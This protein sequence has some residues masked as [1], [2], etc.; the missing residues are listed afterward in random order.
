MKIRMGDLVITG[1]INEIRPLF[2]QLSIRDMETLERID[3]RLH[4][5]LRDL[6]D[7]ELK[8]Q[9]LTKIVERLDETVINSLID[10][11]K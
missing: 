3:K 6:E 5:T 8:M 4:E 11:M 10:A 2:H 7:V 9:T 1:P